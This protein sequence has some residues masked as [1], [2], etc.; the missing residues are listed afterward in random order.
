MGAGPGSWSTGRCCARPWP[1]A[2]DGPALRLCLCPALAQHWSQ[3]AKRAT[4]CQTGTEKVA[5][6]LSRPSRMPPPCGTVV[7]WGLS[8]EPHVFRTP[9]CQGLSRADA[10]LPLP[11]PAPGQ[12]QA[13]R[14]RGPPWHTP[15]EMGLGGICGARTLLL[16]DAVCHSDGSADTRRG[17][18]PVPPQGPG[19][20]RKYQRE[21]SAP[22]LAP[23]HTPAVSLCPPP[24]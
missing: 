24:A 9:R 5:V 23:P 7:K 17:C 13:P 20:G 22:R 11:V 10:G 18:K 4:A 21:P 15:R 12:G 16:P 14:L 2:R 8:S 3:R 19:C 1:C 6:P